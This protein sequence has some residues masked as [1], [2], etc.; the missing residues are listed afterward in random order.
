MSTINELAYSPSSLQKS[1]AFVGR[2]TMLNS[3]Q[4]IGA[5]LKPTITTQPITRPNIDVDYVTFSIK[6]L[7]DGYIGDFNV[8]DVTFTAEQVED[9]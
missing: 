1:E 6:N 8:F 9:V 4:D 7:E 5:Q 2:K 3:F